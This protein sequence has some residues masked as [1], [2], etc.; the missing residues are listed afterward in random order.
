M[1]TTDCNISKSTTWGE[2]YNASIAESSHP[3]KI[4]ELP[5]FTKAL[6]TLKP[7]GNKKTLFLQYTDKIASNN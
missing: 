1:S 6:D 5:T 4:K 7:T 3:S 2:I